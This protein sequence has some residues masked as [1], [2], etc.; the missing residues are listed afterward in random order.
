MRQKVAL[1][2]RGCF[3]I[4]CTPRDSI[5]LNL[6]FKKTI[7]TV[8]ANAIFKICSHRITFWL[9]LLYWKV[10]SLLQ[11]PCEKDVFPLFAAAVVS[12]KH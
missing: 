11:L 3:Y 9:C 8:A 4:V 5:E 12:L 1:N 7:Y 10:R 2:C 6:L